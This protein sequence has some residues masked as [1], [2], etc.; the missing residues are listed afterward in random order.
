MTALP[1]IHLNGSGAEN[2]REEYTAALNALHYAR[3]ALVHTTLNMRDFYP[4]GDEGYIAARKERT[5][6]FR[7]LQEIEEYLAD[8]VVHCH[9]HI[10]RRTAA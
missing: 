2:L 4:Q 8:W 3:E 6:A 9:N 5:E 1:T 7:K 10:E